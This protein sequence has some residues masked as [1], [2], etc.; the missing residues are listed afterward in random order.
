MKA[1]PINLKSHEVRA[2]LDGRKTQTRRVIK[3]ATLIHAECSDMVKP[4]DDGT[5]YMCAHNGT[6]M[7]G[8]FECPYG[9][10]GD[11]LWVREAWSTRKATDPL[12][13]KYIER[14]ATEAGYKSGPYSPLKYRSDGMYTKWGDDDLNQLGGWGKWRPSIHMPRWASRITLEITDIRV[15]RLQEIVPLD[16]V[17]EGIS[18]YAT[19]GTM[20]EHGMAWG[21]VLDG[22]PDDAIYWLADYS[23]ALP[24]DADRAITLDPRESFKALW[25]VVNG[26]ESWKSNPWVWAVS[27]APYL[28]NVDNIK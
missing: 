15:E 20:R 24:E 13:P 17:A 7:T 14:A 5:Y 19:A 2:I 16:A 22:T 11:L 27:F 4:F 25:H 8:Q 18:E 28:V 26:P 3:D 9:K 1:K 6:H 10:P 21:E 12:S 23:A